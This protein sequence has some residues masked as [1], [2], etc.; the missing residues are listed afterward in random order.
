MTS[1]LSFHIHVDNIIPHADKQASQKIFTIWKAANQ[2]FSNIDYQCAS[3]N[4]NKI[5]SLKANLDLSG[6]VEMIESA[7]QRSESLDQYR[8]LHAEDSKTDISAVLAMSLTTAENTEPL[9]IEDGYYIAS[10]FQQ[11]LFLSL[12]LAF[13]GSCKLIGTRLVGP[14]AHL[15]EAQSFDSKIFYDARMS[16]K[17]ENWPTLQSLDLPTIWTWLNTQGFSRT[18][19]A[20]TNI[21][22]VLFNMLKLAQQRHR[23]GSRSALLVSQQFELLLNSQE[24]SSLRNRTQLILG[25]IPEAADCFAALL[26]LRSELMAGNHPIRRPALICHSLTEESSEQIESHN[27]TIELAASIILCM[28]QTLIKSGKDKFKF[29]ESLAE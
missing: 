27:S 22:K 20:I 10:I 2:F 25:D 3:A 12:N 16:C 4:G 18:N 15:Y 7:L 5:L 23:F 28:L 29:K 8:Q 14:N 17:Q 13:P 24:E 19:T 26:K 9:T 21:N 6:A 1:E 11:Q